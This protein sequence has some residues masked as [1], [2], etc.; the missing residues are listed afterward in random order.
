MLEDRYE[1]PFSLRPRC[2]LQCRVS[3][4]NRN[5]EPF[6]AHLACSCSILRHA[7]VM[8]KARDE[9]TRRLTEANPSTLSGGERN[10]HSHRHR[11]IS[12]VPRRGMCPRPGAKL[13]KKHTCNYPAM[14]IFNERHADCSQAH[15][16][17]N[18]NV[19]KGAA[20]RRQEAKMTAGELC[21]ISH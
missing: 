8:H 5:W 19:S 6:S 12:T 18:R 21:D 11:V 9:M 7:R 16:K 14:D 2:P 13:A 20:I 15:V 4:S 3:Q 1:L 17:S 10:R